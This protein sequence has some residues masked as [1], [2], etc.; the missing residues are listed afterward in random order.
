VEP[1]FLQ[2]DQSAIPELR[3]VVLVTQDNIVYATTYQEALSKLMG[4]KLATPTAVG[5]SAKNAPANIATLQSNKQS[6]SQIAKAA[7]ALEEYQK[8]TAQGKYSEAGKELET[9]R[10]LLSKMQHGG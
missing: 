3:L 8:L 10:G 4:E 1:I 9:L 2:A 7:K 5:S 6:S